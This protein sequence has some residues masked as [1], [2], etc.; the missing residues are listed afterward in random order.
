M[1]K[2]KLLAPATSTG[3]GFPEG[4]VEIPGKGTVRVRGLSRWEVLRAERI[5][6]GSLMK[7][8]FVL[9]CA[10]LDPEMGEDD[11][12]EWQKISNPMEINSVAMKVNELSGLTPRAGKEAYKSLRDGSGDGVGLLPGG[13]PAHDGG[14]AAPDDER[15]G[16]AG[17]DGLALA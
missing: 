1:D 13:P 12:A 2:S 3:S 6:G 16:V 4:E 15:T 9:A 17:V 5:D 14:P 7:E 11:I 10:M 8:R